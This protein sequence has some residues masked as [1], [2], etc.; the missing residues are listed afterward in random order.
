MLRLAFAPKTH[1]ARGGSGGAFA[2]YLDNP[3]GPYLGDVGRV[4]VQGDRILLKPPEGPSEYVGWWAIPSG[5]SSR[6]PYL[7]RHRTEAA[8]TL[9]DRWR[10]KAR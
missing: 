4:R 9:Y 10:S 5:E 2:V 7:F 1:M 3:D 8:Q 6:L